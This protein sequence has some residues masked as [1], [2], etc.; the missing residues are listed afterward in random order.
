MKFFKR[1]LKGLLL[2]V[3]LALYTFLVFYR[4]SID[5]N[6]E[7][8][9]VTSFNVITTV[10]FVVAYLFLVAVMMVLFKNGAQILLGMKIK[11]THKD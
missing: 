10:G 4:I 7:R 9:L 6:L 11:L 5:P 1:A 2:L 8:Y 3:P